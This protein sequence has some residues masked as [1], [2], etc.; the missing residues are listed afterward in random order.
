M[1]FQKLF[2]AIIF[3][4]F[5]AK[6]FIYV[7]LCRSLMQRGVIIFL[8]WTPPPPPPPPQ[9]NLYPPSG[10]FNFSDMTVLKFYFLYFYSIFA[11]VKC[12]FAY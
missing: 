11:C 10:H 5:E 1:F 12:I 7:S 9:K 6:F 3:I 8:F 2:V 4:L